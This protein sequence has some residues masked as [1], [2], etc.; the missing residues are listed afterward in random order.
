MGESLDLYFYLIHE[1]IFLIVFIE[2]IFAIF[3][4]KIYLHLNVV[5][6]VFVNLYLNEFDFSLS[7]ICRNFTWYEL[8]SD[9]QIV[10]ACAGLGGAW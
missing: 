1:N 10:A 8:Q 7:V 2:I 6:I 3:I 9:L 4:F 5:L